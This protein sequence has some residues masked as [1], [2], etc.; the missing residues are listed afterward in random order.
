MPDI[1]MCF[2]QYC[3]RRD[4]CYRAMA[5]PDKIQSYGDFET[6]C[7]LHDYRNQIEKVDEYKVNSGGLINELVQIVHGIHT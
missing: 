7:K 2:G 3:P 4:K 6:D 1:S 5:K